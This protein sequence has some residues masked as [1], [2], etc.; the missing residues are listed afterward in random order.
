LLSATSLAFCSAR[1]GR[2]NTINRT[3]LDD[4]KVNLTGSMKLW[5]NGPAPGGTR[6]YGVS[7]EYFRECPLCASSDLEDWYVL[8]RG[9]IRRCQNRECGLGFLVQQPDE[10]QL[11]Q[12]YADHYYPRDD[13][14][15]DFDNS[16][17]AKA[18]QHFEALDGVVGLVGRRVLDY[19][20]GAGRFLR[21]A[22]A[23]GAHVFG[24][25]FDE[26]ARR[27]AVEHGI[28]VRDTI[29]TFKPSSID[30]VYMNDVIEHLRDPVRDLG[31]IRSR[32]RPGGAIFV[33]TMNMDSLTA[34]VRRDSWHIVTN[35][36]HFWFYDELSLR[37][38]LRSA[39]FVKLT[40]ERWPVR[41][42][43]HG[44][45]RSRAQKALQRVGLDASLRMLAWRGD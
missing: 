26:E 35:P 4:T 31:Q 41:F 3:G 24:V 44:P 32:L 9:L 11:V 23:R 37:R 43:H 21:V 39:G 38:T 29:E 42:D 19:G 7:M 36:T 10:T 5:A 34:R 40:V 2:L 1:P 33:V 17:T 18:E 25:E 27:Q 30:V 8:E 22:R 28:D 13:A 14:S 45:V 16:T 6:R 15:P 12:L 20:C